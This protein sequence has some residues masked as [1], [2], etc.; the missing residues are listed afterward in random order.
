[1]VQA[2]SF[3]RL[4]LVDD[5][6]MGVEARATSGDPQVLRL[7]LRLLACSTQIE[8]MLSAR[9]RKTFDTTLPRFDYL[10]QLERFPDGLKMS[11]LSRYLMMSGGN[12]TGLTDQLVKTG[13]VERRPDPADRRLQI[14]SL[15]AQGRQHFLLMA[16]AHE[17][18]L[19][20]ILGRFEAG[21]RNELYELLGRLRVHLV[22]GE[23]K[24]GA[25]NR[26]TQKDAPLGAAR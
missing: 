3:T 16:K 20:E 9:L 2:K 15:T 5:R 18:W 13:W 26:P 7:W 19:V 25:D 1:M 21:H 14:V 10:A 11:A 8:R 4:R 17:R 6:S 12:V 23:D 22:D 24:A